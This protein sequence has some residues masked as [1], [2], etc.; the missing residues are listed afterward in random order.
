MSK[1]KIEINY[2]DILEKFDELKNV[3]RNK[4]LKSAIRGALNITKKQAINNLKGVVNNVNKGE[5]NGDGITFKKGITI[6]I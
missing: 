6:S 3:E 1:S 4:A 2:G 5:Y